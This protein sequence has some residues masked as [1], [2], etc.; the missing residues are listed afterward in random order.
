[1][2]RS[3]RFRDTM[4]QAERELA[5]LVI[6]QEDRPVPLIKDAP[7]TMVVRSR[8]G[9][10]HSEVPTQFTSLLPTM[11]SS[12]LGYHSSG[13][14]SLVASRSHRHWLRCSYWR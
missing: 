9:L 8:K 14:A 4:R 13:S 12:L 3:V 6:E 5:R 7:A 11:T 2:H 10:S 1:M